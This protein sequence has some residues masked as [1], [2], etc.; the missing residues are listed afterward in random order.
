MN[1]RLLQPLILGFSMVTGFAAVTGSPDILDAGIW[2]QHPG[3]TVGKLFANDSRR[4]VV[5]G[6]GHNKLHAWF[7]DGTEAPGFPKTLANQSTALS[8]GG[9]FQTANGFVN[10]T[11]ALVDINGDGN[12]EIFVGSGDGYVYGLDNHGNNLPGWPQFTGVSRGDGVYGV[13][14]SPAVVDLDGDGTFEVIVGAWSHYIY[15]WNAEN[16]SLV[17]GWPFNNADT[18]WSSPAVLDADGDGELEFVIGCD[19]TV[20]RGG[21]LRMFRAD[22]TE[23]AG[24]PKFVDEV[25][26][27]S[28]AVGDIDGDGHPEIVVGTGIFY[29]SGKGQYVSAFETSGSPVA[30]WP[31]S[32]NLPSGLAQVFGSPALADVDGDGKMETFVGDMQG[33]LHCINSNGTIR[34]T[35]TPASSGQ[36]PSD[37]ALFSS[38]VVGDIDGDGRFE[39]VIGG[40]WNITAFDA[41]TG[42][43]EPGYTIETGY[44]DLGG[45]PMITW[46][47]PA[48]A[49][50]DGDGLI[51][52]L[53]GNGRADFPGY[54][55]AGGVRVFHESGSAESAEPVG[56]LGVSPD[57]VPWARFRRDDN[58]GGSYYVEA[59]PTAPPPPP[60]DAFLSGLS[61][62]PD[63]ISP[64]ADGINDTLSIGFD[65]AEADSV[66]V[67]IKDALGRVV[68]RPAVNAA[69]GAGHHSLTWNGTGIDGKVAIDGEYTCAVEGDLSAE[70]SA[71]FGLTLNVPEVSRSWFLAE[72]STVGF[73]AYVLIQNPQA[74]PN[75]VTVTF[76]KQDGT[77]QEYHETVLPRSRTTVAIHG[78]V[79]DVY[80]VSTMVEAEMPIVVERAMY[81][82]KHS[83][84]SSSAHDSIGSI[85][86]AKTF[87]FPAN[88]TL[89]GDEDFILLVNPSTTAVAHVTARFFT[90]DQA[91]IEQTYT[92]LTTSR[93][94]IPVHAVLQNKW[95]SVEVTSDQPLAAERAF[96]FDSRRGGAADIGAISPSLTF[97]FPDGDTTQGSTYLEMMNPGTTNAN[98]T[99]TYRTDNGETINRVKMIGAER[100][101]SVNCLNDMGSSRLFSIE[102]HSDQPIVAQRFMFMGNDVGDTLGSPIATR[103]WNLAE[104]FTAFGYETWVTVFNP[105]A[106]SAQVQV[107]FQ[108]QNGVNVFKNYVILSKGRTRIYV[109]DWVEPTSVSTQV[110]SDV[111]IVVE[112]TMRFSDRHGIHQALGVR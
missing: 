110:T 67:S 73:E 34:W 70:I 57:L 31:V 97:Y 106:T 8:Q 81:F 102:V 64:N 49:D 29:R 11:P 54:A 10:S 37:F 32:V 52:L 18:V 30:G 77:T 72:G 93:Y 13:F 19:S 63:V 42:V 46:S 14:S 53:I 36:N 38:P 45:T 80:S 24:W 7:P 92:V 6:D 84:S 89:T 78:E 48:I 12:L 35:N 3:V 94:T 58:G 16:G 59:E 41:Q 108:Q 9:I 71:K 87:Y 95:A 103:L 85:Q 68:A 83:Y 2:V 44:P 88:R 79:P 47:T 51:D 100:R 1:Y 43:K 82:K 27:S 33:Y 65:L 75:P 112:R 15:V 91:P 105:S 40:G 86:T 90:S 20:P 111:P 39:V 5:V 66:T 98:V 26:W 96:Y 69:M 56:A 99:V 76:V 74:T 23:M 61:V 50:F 55:D 4:L 107:R 62:S 22:G 109:N 25:I 101:I 28:P 21:Y 60:K 17:D 104:G